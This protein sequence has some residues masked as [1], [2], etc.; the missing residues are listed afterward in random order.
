MPTLAHQILEYAAQLPE[1]APLVAKGLLHLSE[2]AAVDQA[3]SRLVKRAALLR[4]GRGVY[5]LPVVNRFDARAPSSAKMVEGMALQR[6]E[7]IVSHGAGAANA[8]GLTTQVPMRAIYLTSGRSRSLKLGAQVIELRH[9]PAWQ[10]ILPWQAAG[11]VIRALAWLG[12]EK[13]GMAISTLR[14]PP[15]R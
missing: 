13:A 3:L 6:G 7:T 5:A 11:D 10:Q 1:G 8:L 9:A 2:R 4:A 14:A 12:P 15:P